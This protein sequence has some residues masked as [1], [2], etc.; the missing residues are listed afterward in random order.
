MHQV[1]WAYRRRFVTTMQH[2]LLHQ[3]TS[4]HFP[5][6]QPIDRRQTPF[7]AYTAVLSAIG[8][9]SGISLQHPRCRPTGPNVI[10]SED[11]DNGRLML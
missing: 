11:T 6:D 5:T 1:Y 3:V 9:L 10:D 4:F 8:A 2:T 7:L